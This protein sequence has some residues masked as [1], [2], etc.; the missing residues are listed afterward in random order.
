LEIGFNSV[1]SVVEIGFSLFNE[2]AYEFR[3]RAVAQLSLF[4]L[5]GRAQKFSRLTR[6]R[7]WERV[8]K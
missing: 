6:E 8:P 4:C 1:S 5:Q 7:R 3:L 2:R